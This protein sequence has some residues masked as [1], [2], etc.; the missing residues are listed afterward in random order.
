VFH[1]SMWKL[2]QS[3]LDDLITNCTGGL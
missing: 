2:S 1:F 3:D